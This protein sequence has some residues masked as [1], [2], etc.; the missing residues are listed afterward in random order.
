V[1]GPEAV[2]D[3]QHLVEPEGESAR[4]DAA[5][6]GHN[7]RAWLVED[8]VP[9][10]YPSRSIGLD[11]FDDRT[12]DIG[13]RLA[14]L[15][16]PYENDRPRARATASSNCINSR[17]AG[18]TLGARTPPSDTPAANSASG[19]ASTDVISHHAHSR[20]RRELGRR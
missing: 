18:L 14:R 15:V 1:A 11:P 4:F 5:A 7:E 8:I 16:E 13:R 20:V 12:R 17:W 2:E 9:F 19:I 3:P 10:R 6:R